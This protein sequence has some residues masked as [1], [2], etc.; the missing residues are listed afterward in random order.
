MYG[1]KDTKTKQVVCWC[2][3]YEEAKDEV[4]QLKFNDKLEGY[5]TYYEIIKRNTKKGC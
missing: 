5:K 3:T 2:D 1:I 4:V